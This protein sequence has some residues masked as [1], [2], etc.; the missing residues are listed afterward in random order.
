MT[1]KRGRPRRPALHLTRARAARLFR[2]AVVLVEAPRT[3]EQLLVSLRIGLRTFYREV[4]LLTRVGIRVRLINKRYELHTPLSEVEQQ[5]PFPDPQLTF[6][7]MKELSGSAGPAAER[8]ALLYQ[9][10][11][12]LATPVV[13]TPRGRS[14]KT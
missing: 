1:K 9:E 7:E 13:A 6:G 8:L 3:R 10:V 2:L 11:V 12:A 4:E 5:L 14:K